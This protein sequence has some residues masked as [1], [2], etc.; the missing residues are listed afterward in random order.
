[1]EGEGMAKKAQGMTKDQVWVRE[2][3]KEAQGIKSRLGVSGFGRAFGTL[4]R[5]QLPNIELGGLARPGG[6]VRKREC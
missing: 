2:Q 1:M 3:T 5:Q 6:K 4:L